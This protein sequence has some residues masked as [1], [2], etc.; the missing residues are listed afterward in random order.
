MVAIQ[1]KV[2]LILGI[3]KRLDVF[4]INGL[5]FYFKKIFQKDNLDKL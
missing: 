4:N 1:S 2:N 3:L 5:R